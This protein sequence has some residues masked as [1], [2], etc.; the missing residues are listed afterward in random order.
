M[1]ARFALI[2]LREPDRGIAESQRQ[3]LNSA[4]K[5][6]KYF[7]APAVHKNMASAFQTSLLSSPDLTRAQCDPINTLSAHPKAA[8][9]LWIIIACRDSKTQRKRKSPQ[10]TSWSSL[11]AGERPSQQSSIYL[12]SQQ[13]QIFKDGQTSI[14]GDYIVV[15]KPWLCAQSYLYRDICSHLYIIKPHFNLLLFVS[16]HLIVV[17]ARGGKPICLSRHWSLVLYSDVQ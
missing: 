15:R 2:H 16:F 9:I 7:I 1:K 14:C 10:A 11:Q 6:T 4:L 5:V 17:G 3:T 8:L 13:P 12:L